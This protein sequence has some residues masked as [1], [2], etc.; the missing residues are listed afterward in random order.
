MEYGHGGDIYTYR[1]M[2]DFSVNV[3]PLGL[4]RKVIEAAK[5]GVER[6]AQ[7]PDSRCRELR[8]K[9]VFF[10][11]V[12]KMAETLIH[13]QANLS[14]FTPVR[15]PAEKFSFNHLSRRIGGTAQ[16]NNIR[17]R[18]QTFQKS[19]CQGELLLPAQNILLNPAA[20]C[21]E[22]MRILG[23]SR[24]RDHRPFRLFHQPFLRAPLFLGGS[25]WAGGRVGGR[26]LK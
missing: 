22:C 3:N 25:L 23:K 6:A 5:K 15:D 26:G 11:V 2:L 19:L 17:L 24:N 18:C 12:E 14:L 8:D 9:C 16:E 13:H 7:Y 21:P 4:S 1:D 10:R 20:H